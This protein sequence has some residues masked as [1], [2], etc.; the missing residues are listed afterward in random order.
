MP[1]AEHRSDAALQHPLLDDN[2][3]GRDM[4]FPD[5]DGKRADEVYLGAILP[6]STNFGG[7][8]AEILLTAETKHLPA[9]ENR[10]DLWIAVNSANRV[11]SA[12]M[13]I[14]LPAT[15]L[16]RSVQLVTEQQEIDQLLRIPTMTCTHKTLPHTCAASAA[17]FTD[18]GMYEIFYFV[19]DSVTDGISPIKRSLVY[20]N[21]AGNEPPAAFDLLFPENMP[22]T[23][24]CDDGT[25]ACRPQT[26][27]LDWQGSADPESHAV[28]YTLLLADPKKLP[29]DP[30][31]FD[32]IT[33]SNFDDY[34]VY[35]EE[36]LKESMAGI[37]AEARIWDG[38]TDG[39]AGLKDETT[40]Y[41]KVLAV[42]AY[43]AT[44]ESAVWRF[45][46]DSPN[47]PGNIVYGSVNSAVDYSFLDDAKL[48]F[49]KTNTNIQVNV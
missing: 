27:L 37:G 7:D 24:A 33:F 28:T 31:P 39:V 4:L 46:I 25:I 40:Y 22:P 13:D 12:S 43:G 49:I 16:Q 32:A 19:R 2:G 35:R 15:E 6:S 1:S 5:N 14:R 11:N 21:F 38:R 42:D 44:I 3:D 47:S 34:V 23:A 9:G 48:R 8:P 45:V 30:A 29:V 10:A 41:W 18:P 17:L 36:E 26:V 20:K